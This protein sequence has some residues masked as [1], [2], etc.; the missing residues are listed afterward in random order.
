MKITRCIRLIIQHTQNDPK[1]V[2][3][4]FYIMKMKLDEENVLLKRSSFELNSYLPI[5]NSI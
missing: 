2:R 1:N 5:R 3:E 4:Y